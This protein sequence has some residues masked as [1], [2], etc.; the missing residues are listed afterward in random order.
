MTKGRMTW[1]KLSSLKQP[2]YHLDHGEGSARGLYVVVTPGKHAISRS[3][4][5]RYRSPLHGG[6]IR[7]MGLGPCA[8]VGLADARKLAVEARL[9]VKA[10]RDPLDERQAT[11]TKARQETLRESASRMTFKQCAD[12]YLAEHLATFKNAT[13]R[14]QWRSSINSANKAFGSLHVASV[15]TDVVVKFLTPHWRRAAVSA[16]RTRGRIAAVLQ[17]AKASGFR[18]G[19]NPAEWDGHLE[20]LFKRKPDVKHHAALPHSGIPAFMA[21]LRERNSISAMALEICIL[22]ATR[23]TETI[24]A[25]W[26]EFDLDAGIWVVP[27]VR[28][29][30]KVDHSI[31]LSP[32][33]LAILRGLPRDPS[34]FV[35][36]GA[37]AG[38][39]ISNMAMLQLLRGMSG[40]GYTVHGFRS[41]FRDWCGE[42]TAFPRDIIEFALAHK[43]K[44]KAE[45]A[46]R[47]ETAVEKRR[48]LMTAWSSYCESP[49]TVAASNVTPIGKRA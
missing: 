34:G 42:C 11:R 46:Y 24:A 47:R 35:F 21:E 19:D 4:I 15:T 41:C 23:T 13:H 49:P 12:H 32:R 29:K 28:M 1:T 26:E 9:A 48:K 16:D 17:W 14:Q 25:R 27:G 37:K 10:G 2:G 33:A 44:D 5:Y 36:P 7:D 43:I 38:K 20:H 31:P 8:L 40:N 22:T 18:T 45:A 3:W 30:G 39:P 6:R